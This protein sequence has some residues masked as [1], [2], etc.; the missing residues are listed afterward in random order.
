MSTKDLICK[1]S[2][3]YADFLYSILHDLTIIRAPK[4]FFIFE[5]LNPIVD[6][7]SVLTLTKYYKKIT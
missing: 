7:A 2:S 1:S 3:K 6:N 4:S 5:L